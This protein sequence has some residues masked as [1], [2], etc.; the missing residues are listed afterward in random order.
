MQIKGSCNIEIKPTV[1]QSRIGLKYDNVM[2]IVCENVRLKKQGNAYIDDTHL[3]IDFEIN[4]KEAYTGVCFL[5]CLCR[6]PVEQ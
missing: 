5:T 2:Y 6:F 1:N 3:M 4:C